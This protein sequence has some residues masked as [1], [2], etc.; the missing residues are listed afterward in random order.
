MERSRCEYVH[1]SHADPC[2]ENQ[3]ALLIMTDAAELLNSTCHSSSVPSS[4]NDCRVPLLHP[5]LRLCGVVE[6][7]SL[8]DTAALCCLSIPQI[9]D[10][11]LFEMSPLSLSLH[12]SLFPLLVCKK[13][14]CA[15]DL[16]TFSWCFRCF[17]LHLCF[18]ETQCNDQQNQ[19]TC[20]ELLLLAWSFKL[21][22]K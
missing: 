22:C 3:R 21:L 18:G 2:E 7:P 1:F 16:S 8:T 14:V 5:S 10:L 15:S 11:N 9:R 4:A 20:D 17:L 12:H 6:A 13:L 19:L